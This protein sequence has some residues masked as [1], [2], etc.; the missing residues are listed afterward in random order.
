MSMWVRG[1]SLLGMDN[2]RAFLKKAALLSAAGLPGVLPGSIQKAFAI[3]PEAGTTYLDAEHVVILMQENRSFDHTFGT[4][5]G[6]RGFND[7]RAIDL[8]NRNKVW[9][10][11]DE[12]GDTYVPFRYNLKDTKITWMSSLPHRWKDQSDARNHGLYDKW[13]EAKK[14]G[15]AEYRSMP[16]P[17]GYYTREDVPFYYAL[18]DAFTVC[19]QYFCSSFT[20]T[21]PNRLY[22]WTGTIRSAPHAGV[23]A[24]VRNGDVDYGRWQSW[25]TFPERLEDHGVSWKI[26]QNELSLDKGLPFDE[27]EWLCNFT[28]N[29]I[30]W[31]EQ[32]HVR[33]SPGYHAWLIGQRATL[34]KEVADR[35]QKLAEAQADAAKGG[36]N[37]PTPGQLNDMR[38]DLKEMEAFLNRLEDEIRDWEPGGF[39]RLSERA[40]RLHA[41][42]FCCNEGDPDYHTLM[43]HRYM[44]GAVE[45]EVR[46]P[47]GDVLHQFRE[48][49]Q[50]GTLPTVSWLV[51][52]ARFSDHPGGPWYGVWYLSEVMDILTQ[53]PEV[54]K[55]TIFIINYDENDGYFD[56]VP[57]FVAPDPAIP[58]S[59]KA[60]AHIDTA[61][62]HVT[63]QQEMDYARREGE[64]VEDGRAG[65]IGLGYRVP[66]IVASPWSRG[67][68]VCSQVFDHTSVLQFLEH[69]LQH[70]TG[71]KI[72]ES[73]IT[74]WR[75]TVCGD[76]RSVFKPYNGEA[77]PDLQPVDRSAHVELI[78][79]ARFKPVIS[80]FRP[81]T[82]DEIGRINRDAMH[83]E[84]LPGQEKG[85]RVARPLPYELYVDGGL[86][87]ARRRVELSFEAGRAIFGR[88][89]AG[90]PFM[91]YATGSWKD[92]AWYHPIP[93]SV[94]ASAASAA[95]GPRRRVWNYTVAAGDTLKDGWDLADFEGGIYLLEVYGP[96]GFYRR[97]A[98]DASD[99]VASV[100]CM[101]QRNRWSNNVLTGN[102]QIELV[103]GSGRSVVTVKDN[104]YGASVFTR[105][106]EAGERLVLPI[107]CSRSHGWYDC[108]VSVEG[109][110]SF[111][112]RYA[113]HVE[114]G[115]ESMSDPLM[116]GVV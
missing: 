48:D 94:A 99:P 51:A 10:Q 35:R 53:H 39:D 32:Y 72:E 41:K 45:R 64:P 66:M 74:E 31:F 60:S 30:E 69:Y 24:N 12:K 18:A 84:L 113:G 79:N 33:F 56:H 22:H 105:T 1:M 75:R 29:P 52:P 4:L 115:K 55:K 34:P 8:P 49:V 116:G 63:L 104:A 37:A 61:V 114:T 16:L 88:R 81:L 90:A 77:L 108:T 85:V 101:Y 43:T 11:T 38:G 71:R 98:G 42:A 107:D 25:P 112:R 15:N 62:E 9:M 57:P 26:Y 2:R 58:G 93:G 103:G 102:I 28:D 27:Q 65:P 70:R 7:P 36:P 73:N 92:G 23:P 19:D 86:D 95:A 40:K 78:N 5:R 83:T 67:G 46:I 3:H 110:S 13:L 21:T 100:T 54:W 91:V 87:G 89:S 59:G 80:N 14:S 82:A 111:E 96:N 106:L 20:G 47:K 109:Y 50:G 97:L 68:A 6:V 17:L 76:L 44:D